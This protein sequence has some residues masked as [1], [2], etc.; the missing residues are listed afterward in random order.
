MLCIYNVHDTYKYAGRAGSREPGRQP[1]AAQAA[2]ASKLRSQDAPAAAEPAAPAR[3]GTPGNCISFRPPNPLAD[4]VSSNNEQ[5]AAT[6]S[7]SKHPASTAFCLVRCNAL[8]PDKQSMIHC[9][10]QKVDSRQQT[11]TS[12]TFTSSCSPSTITGDISVLIAVFLSF[13]KQMW[14]G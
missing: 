8:H 2:P 11:G 1:R 13:R 5:V 4:D 10:M 12:I 3:P 9:T 7:S 14:M 6:N